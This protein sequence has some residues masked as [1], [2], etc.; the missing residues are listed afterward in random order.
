MLEPP[1]CSRPPPRRRRRRARFRARSR[2]RP[3]CSCWW[4]RSGA[5]RGDRR[6]ALLSTAGAPWTDMILDRRGVVANGRRF[7]H[8][9]K[10]AREPPARLRADLLVHRRQRCRSHRLNRDADRRLVGRLD[11]NAPLAID[12]DPRDGQR[13]R[14]HGER[15]SLGACPVCCRSGSGCWGW[16]RS[17]SARS[18]RRMRDIYVHG[19]ATVGDDHRGQGHRH[20]HQLAAGDPDRLRLPVHLRPDR[21]ATTSRRPPAIGGAKIW[22]LYDES[23]PRRNV[24]ATEGRRPAFTM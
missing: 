7:G 1:C 15:A 23:Y 12:Y 21:G 13:T 5:G 19:Q 17:R 18:N 11:L 24:P 22:G 6:P 8:A 14:V 3:R 2:R 20:P 10:H 9:P 4:A 16:S